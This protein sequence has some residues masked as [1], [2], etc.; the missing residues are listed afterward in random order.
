MRAFI[1]NFD[2][3]SLAVVGLGGL[4][5]AVWL[6]ALDLGLILAAVTLLIGTIVL[7]TRH[8]WIEIGLLMTA[9]GLVTVAGYSLLGDPEPPPIVRTPGLPSAYEAIP[10]ETFAPGMA[11]L[12]LV[13]GL[14]LI[15]V[16]GAWD[17]SNARRRLR[18][19]AR[20]EARRARRAARN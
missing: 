11:W 14:A 12:L 13:G 8:R 1:G 4:I 9:I 3:V 15:V 20:H 5:G 17:L 10:V 19:E 2:H 18:L 7:I 16:I 6:V